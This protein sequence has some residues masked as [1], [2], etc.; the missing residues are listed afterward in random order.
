MVDQQNLA[1]LVH[2]IRSYEGKNFSYDRID[3][4]GVAG[5]LTVDWTLSEQEAAQLISDLLIE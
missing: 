5:K 3:S 1:D 4:E 2:R